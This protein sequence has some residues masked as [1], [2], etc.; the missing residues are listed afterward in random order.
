MLNLFCQICGKPLK[1]HKDR[2]PHS[3][4]VRIRCPECKGIF[5]YVPSETGGGEIVG[6]DSVVEV[7][8]D[9]LFSMEARDLWKLLHSQVFWLI[10]ALAGMPLILSMF[11]IEIV[12][13]MSV[14]FSMIW[15]CVFIKL[16]QHEGSN[17]RLHAGIYIISLVLLSPV[18]LLIS[19]VTSPFYAFINSPSI[20]LR[21]IGFFT[22]VGLTEELTKAVPILLLAAYVRW[23]GEHLSGMDYL[24]CGIASGLAFAG[25]ENLGY[26]RM[27]VIRGI[28]RGSIGD[29]AVTS[30]VRSTLTPFIHACLSGIFAYFIGL[31]SLYPA[32]SPWPFILAGLLVSAFLHAIYDFSA[33]LPIFHQFLAFLALAL[34]YMGL[35]ICW[36]NLK[37]KVRRTR[38]REVD[39]FIRNIF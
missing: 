30:L 17:F 25:V 29:G 33:T 26:I 15:F 5:L 36:L 2:L 6:A 12:R 35:L 4:Q 20:F 37:T 31:M 7:V 19:A 11:K 9:E 32:K 28:F 16:F 34:M 13:G 38:T 10:L 23:K 24:L 27:A 8:K 21:F 22:G 1:I 3:D 14:Y 39:G 18:Y